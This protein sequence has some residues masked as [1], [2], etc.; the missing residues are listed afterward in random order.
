MNTGK[1]AP[2]LAELDRR[3]AE[4]RRRQAEKDVAHAAT[5][6]A[7]RAQHGSLAMGT[8]GTPHPAPQPA[9]PDDTEAQA[10]REYE[11][12]TALPAEFGDVETYLA[13]RRAEAAGRV[14][15]FG[16]PRR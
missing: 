1:H 12:S 2:F 9:T 10:R 6:A 5:L 8:A 4:C 11:L 7:R 16:V 13:F 3:L 14:K 15:I